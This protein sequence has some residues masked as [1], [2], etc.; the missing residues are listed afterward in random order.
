MS[1]PQSADSVRYGSKPVSRDGG[2]ILAC[3]SAAS[4]T[5]QGDIVVPKDLPRN[6][7]SGTVSQD[8]ISRADQSLMRQTPNTCSANLPAGTGSPGWLGTPA[9]KPS[10]ASKSSRAHGPNSGLPVPRGLDWPYGRR[11]G[12]PD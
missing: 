12:V 10:S 3:S 1:R 8:W 11:T 9:T 5:I 4:G 2:W 6:G 7:P